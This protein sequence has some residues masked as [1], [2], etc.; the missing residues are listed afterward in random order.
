MFYRQT[1]AINLQNG[2]Y[3]RSRDVLKNIAEIYRGI[4]AKNRAILGDKLEISMEIL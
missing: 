3:L 2:D 4:I 1:T